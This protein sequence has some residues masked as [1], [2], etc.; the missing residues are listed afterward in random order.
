MEIIVPAELFG[1]VEQGMTARVTPDL[2][3]AVAMQANVVLVDKL[4]DPASNTFRVR[5]ALPNAESAIPSGLRCRAELLATDEQFHAAPS[6]TTEPKDTAGPRP[7]D[8]KLDLDLSTTKGRKPA[9]TRR[10]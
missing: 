7:A 3:N 6:P 9:Q 5:A 10:Q 2:P 4:I 1:T 8:L